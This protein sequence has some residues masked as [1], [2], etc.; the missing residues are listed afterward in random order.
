M[1]G[2]WLAGAQNLELQKNN[3]MSHFYYRTYVWKSSS[4]AKEIYLE[5]G[6][7]AGFPDVLLQLV[8]PNQLVMLTPVTSFSSPS[9]KTPPSLVL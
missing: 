2:H 5:F 1:I 9:Q 8:S 4:D 3:A 6:W 7:A